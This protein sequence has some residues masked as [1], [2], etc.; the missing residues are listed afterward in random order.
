MDSDVAKDLPARI[1]SDSMG[2]LPIKPGVLWGA[3]TQRSLRNFPIGGEE[4]K[5]PLAVVRGMAIVKKCCALYHKDNGLMDGQVADAI[6]Q[7]ADEIL[8]GALDR[9]FPL[10]T[11]QTGRYGSTHSFLQLLVDI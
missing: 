9:H 2:E 1:E 5:M 8:T 4:S 6:A 3:Q 7:A 11:F 10:V